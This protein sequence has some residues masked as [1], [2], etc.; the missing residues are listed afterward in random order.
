MEAALS[1]K[2][3]LGVVII[4]SLQGLKIREIACMLQ[5]NRKTVESRYN[6]AKQQLEI[7]LKN[8]F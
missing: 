4:C 3:I 8:A 2:H 7:L 5:L 6:R 1:L